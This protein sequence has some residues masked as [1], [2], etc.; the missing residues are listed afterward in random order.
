V[1]LTVTE[2]CLV[3]ALYLGLAAMPVSLVA[4]TSLSKN[5]YMRMLNLRP[6]RARGRH[7]LWMG[8]EALYRRPRTTKP[9]P[10]HKVYPNLLRGMEVVLP[11]AD[12]Y[13][14]CGKVRH[15]SIQQ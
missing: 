12:D 8:I 9:E 5:G 14:L 10:G 6:Q 13:S 2:I 4:A 11:Q 1:G 7:P 15:V 3:V